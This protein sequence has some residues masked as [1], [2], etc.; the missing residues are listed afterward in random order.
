[1][2]LKMKKDRP[3]DK[4]KPFVIKFQPAYP[5]PKD[6]DE[7]ITKAKAP[8]IHRFDKLPTLEEA[9]EVGLPV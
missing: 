8:F 5:L 1:M 4:D 9:L 2:I 6:E 7:D 3:L